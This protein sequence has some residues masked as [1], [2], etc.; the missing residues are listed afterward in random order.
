MKAKKNNFL[1][2]LMG[3]IALATVCVTRCV[4]TATSAPWS[5]T[6]LSP[7]SMAMI[8]SQ[9]QPNIRQYYQPDSSSGEGVI[10][11]RTNTRTFTTIRLFRRDGT[12]KN[13]CMFTILF[14]YIILI[15][16]FRHRKTA[17]EPRS[18]DV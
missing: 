17:K 7:K 4:I 8:P 9:L 16:F 13:V 14:V 2:I 1:V 11:S 10:L 18:R 12:E 6:S 5:A 15:V 3:T